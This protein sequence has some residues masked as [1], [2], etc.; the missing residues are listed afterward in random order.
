MWPEPGREWNFNQAQRKN[1]VT[2]RP[3][4]ETQVVLWTLRP[5]VAS[6]GQFLPR[7]LQS[8]H[9]FQLARPLTCLVKLSDQGCLLIV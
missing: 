7:L 8:T 9:I 3:E 4:A 5:Y 2:S 6:D 1:L